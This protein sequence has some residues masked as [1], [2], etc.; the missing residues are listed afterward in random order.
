[1]ANE[2]GSL[3]RRGVAAYLAVHGLLGRGLPAAGHQGL[4]PF[5][6]RLEFETDEPTDD[7][8]CRL[9]NGSAMYVSAK[10]ACGDDRDL[11]STVQQWAAQAPV[12]GEN[13]LL[14]LAVAEPRGVVK[15]L[16]A[17]LLKQ[18]AGSPTY[19]AGEA[20]AL[21]ALRR[22]L[23]GKSEAVRDRV[24]SAARVLKIDAVDAGDPEFDLAAA[25]LEGSVVAPPYGAEAVRALSLSMHTQAGIASSSGA[26]DWVRVLRAAD[27]T[28]YADRRGPRGAAIMGRQAAV[29]GYR[30]RL[31]EHYGY[32]DLSLL[33]DDLPPLRIDTLAGSLRVAMNDGQDRQEERPLLVVAR[34]WLR[35][36]LVGLPGSGK[37][38]ALRQLAAAWAGDGR[39]PVPVLVSLSTVARRCSGHVSLTLSMMCEAAA[40]SAPSEQ[41]AV[42]A[43]A[44]EDLC[45]SG[46]AVLM[47]D[48]L[49]EC[50]DRRALI[51]DGLSALAGSLPP[52]TGL[53][54]ATRGSGERSARRLGLPVA[55]LVRP[56]GLDLVMQ[57]LLEHVAAV[58]VP[59]CDRPVW[60]A[61]RASWLDQ[62]R[63]RYSEMSSVPLLAT[64]LV[65]IA[66]GSADNKLPGS[67]ARLLMTAVTESVRR[68]E[69][70]RAEPDDHT[71]WP[72]DG[73]LLDGYAAVGHRLAAVGEI[74]TAEAAAAVSGILEDRWG[75]A[76]GAAAE[77]SGRILWFWDEH[78]GVFVRTDAGVVASRSR[79]FC[80]IASAMRVTTLPE[81]RIADWVTESLRDPDRDESLQLAAELEP[82]V[83]AALLTEDNADVR[84][85]AALVAAAAVQNGMVVRP[86]QITTLID[87]LAWGAAQGIT[88]PQT[89]GAAEPAMV[90]P[91]DREQRD[92]K[93]WACARTLAGLPLPAALHDRRRNL[94]NDLCLNSEQQTITQAL[95]ALSEAETSGGPPSGQ[96]EHAIRRALDLPLPRK[97]R[98]RRSPQGHLVFRSGPSLLTGHVEVAIGAAR[99]L[100]TV[101][102][103]LARR[104][105]EIGNRSSFLVYPQVAQALANRG[106]RFTPAWTRQFRQMQQTLAIWNDHPELPLLQAAARL[107]DSN[108]T[109]SSANAW[110]LTDLLDLFA[111]L[112][113]PR[114]AANDLLAAVISD[115]DE[116]RDIWLNCVVTVSDLDAS[117]IAAQARHA[118]S[119]CEQPDKT[120]SHHI[121]ELILTT[122]PGQI[123]EIHGARPS[124]K[125][126]GVLVGLLSARSDWIADTSCDML[127]GTRS[128]SLHEQLLA[129]LAQLPAPRRRNAAITAITAARNPI[130][131]AAALLDQPD[132]AARAGAARLLGLLL[133]PNAEAQALLRKVGKDD[134][135]TIRV[136]SRRPAVSHPPPTTWSCRLCAGYNDPAEADCRHCGQRTRPVTTP[137]DQ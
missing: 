67:R 21:E 62:A 56:L 54:V 38:L 79:V 69:R 9:S 123:P 63:D 137:V 96:E 93:G 35:M 37:S 30:A 71:D 61:S 7:I 133:A 94:L 131:A 110:R 14:V 46:E 70:Q 74:S 5:P 15:H 113:A 126:Q 119:E 17:A 129:A 31:S 42:L 39:A 32:L 55:T 28:V 29:E 87:S 135:L 125:T 84:Q 52:D 89:A 106:Y 3:H 103:K 80:E 4:G 120:K 99:H 127:R 26:E 105:H 44:L 122:P 40:Q 108:I 41:R 43:A 58:R 134:D 27:I 124:P 132:P 36:L 117:A 76:P 85:S 6:V 13:D 78:V 10:R 115:T 104:I 116:T 49:D 18:H 100:E 45:G 50:L 114:V 98:T 2:A 88:A 60:V 136:A 11:S 23:A 81:R 107:S 82:M 77:T 86:D 33:A 102:S 101:D 73:Q 97:Q 95:R 47:L 59:E 51:A 22:L 66:A 118:I 24:L 16:G 130:Q 92:T 111:V 19:L 64:L 128:E 57:Q 72:T 90:R 25:M 53:I 8:T 48:G 68:W 112:G 83:I 109:I 91:E 75:F 65:L 34:R 1:M 20:S 121:L 12:L